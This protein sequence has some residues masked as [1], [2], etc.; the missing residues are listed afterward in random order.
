LHF[1]T[2]HEF[3]QTIV[4]GPGELHLESFVDRIRREFK[5]EADVGAPQVVYRET[6][7]K[8]VEVDHTHKSQ[9]GGS[10]QFGR[11]KIT[12][13]PAERG[14]GVLFF[15]EITGGNIPREYIPSVEKG[16]RDT[17]GVGSLGFPMIDIEIHLTDGAYHD[18]NSSAVAFEITGRG[19]MREAA[20]KAGIKLLEPIMNVEVAT[21]D[22]YLGDVIAALNSRRAQ[23]QRTATSGHAQVVAATAPMAQLFG[24]EKE[25]KSLTAG[26]AVV[27]I[28]WDRYELVEPNGTD[29]DDTFPPVAALRA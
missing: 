6:L 22:D 5:V 8:A 19:A 24:M 16:M 4:K 12:V 21:P 25:L 20:Q 18:I 28:V 1:T 26:R 2:D 9:F 7:A 13:A 14:S 11:V 3:G 17:A 23:I 27:E 15:D 29:P 10:S